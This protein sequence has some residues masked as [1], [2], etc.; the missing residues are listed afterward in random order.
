MATPAH[1]RF[2][3]F[4]PVAQV[5]GRLPMWERVAVGVAGALVVVTVTAAATIHVPEKKPV[6]KLA[7]EK[8]VT[9][10][11]AVSDK[12]EDLGTYMRTE[13]RLINITSLEKQA[14]DQSQTQEVA[15]IR[16]QLQ[17]PGLPQPVAVER[18]RKQKTALASN[19]SSAAVKSNPAPQPEQPTLI[20]DGAKETLQTLEAFKVAMK[21]VGIEHAEAG[22]STYKE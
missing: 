20:S 16:A 14:L 12:W 7:Y 6:P 1:P 10:P 2:G 17:S 9:I 18:K 8:K 11:I 15:A 19:D 4:R 3:F 21:Q 5:W 22:F 13:R